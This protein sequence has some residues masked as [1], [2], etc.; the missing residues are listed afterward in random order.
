FGEYSVLQGSIAALIPYNRV[1]G[2]FSTGNKINNSNSTLLSF[3][4]YLR[5]DG[6]HTNS[7]IFDDY[8]DT[9]H[10]NNDIQKGL[11]FNSTIPQNKGLGSSGAICAAIY[12]CYK[13]KALNELSDLR[14]LFSHME[15][16]FHGNSSGIDPLCIYLNRPLILRNEEYILV[17]D[18]VHLNRNFVKPFLVDTGTESKTEPLVHHFRELMEQKNYATG[19]GGIYIPLVNEAVNQWKDGE[20]SHRIVADLSMAQQKYLTRMI[21]DE[22]KKVWE[23]GLDNDL[24]AMKLCGSGGGG[25]ILG[26]TNK[27]IET[28]IYLKK[29]FDINIITV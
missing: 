2:Q 13:R 23:S 15:S 21:P 25:M 6:H 29:Q 26:F 12:D 28:G 10:L 20:L 24:Y 14:K 27:M 19:F 16:W 22:Y 8:I 5:R 4:E 3:L 18:D 11:F 9:E 7:I 17:N 1:N